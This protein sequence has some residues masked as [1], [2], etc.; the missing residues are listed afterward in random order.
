MARPGGG[1]EARRTREVATLAAGE[2][3]GTTWTGRCSSD[4]PSSARAACASVAEENC[5]YTTPVLRP[6]AGSLRWLICSM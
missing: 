3:L 2:S 5:M 1:K 6:L 4:E